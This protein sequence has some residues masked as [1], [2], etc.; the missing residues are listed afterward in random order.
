LIT[1]IE[2]LRETPALSIRYCKSEFYRIFEKKKI[3]LGLDRRSAVGVESKHS[4]HFEVLDFQE[5][6]YY[7]FIYVQI[8]SAGLRNEDKNESSQHCGMSFGFIWNCS[9]ST[10][11][12]NG[13]SDSRDALNLRNLYHS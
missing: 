1:F 3:G 6:Y 12:A 11:G 4:R 9:S 7:D 2:F 5:N 10:F 13:L 8:F